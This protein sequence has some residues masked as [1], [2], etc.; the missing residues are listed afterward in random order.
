MPKNRDFGLLSKIESLVFARNDLKWSVIWL[1]NFLHKSHIWENSRTRDLGQKYGKN[2]VFGLLRKI[3]SLVFASNDLKWSVIWLANFLWKSHIW[4]NCRSL[5][6]GQ[7]GPKKGK[8]RVFGLLH[9]MP[10][11]NT[12][13]KDFENLISYINSWWNVLSD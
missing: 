13:V 5:D 7:K 3:E 8:N 9:K 12:T 4:E 1:A 6:L 10:I 2:R 11:S